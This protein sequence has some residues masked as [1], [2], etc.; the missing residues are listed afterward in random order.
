MISLATDR[1]FMKLCAT[2]VCIILG[3]MEE[4]KAIA[5]IFENLILILENNVRE[6]ALKCFII[7]SSLY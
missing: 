5:N 6:G 3:E 4:V 7:Y 2:H 1:R